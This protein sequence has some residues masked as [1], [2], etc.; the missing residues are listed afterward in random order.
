VFD[1]LLG[2]RLGAAAVEHI[3]AGTT[4]VLLGLRGSAI[5]S[6][7]LD[8]VVATRRTLDPRL[9]DLARVLAR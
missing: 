5:A 8:E 2:T 6:T 3:A 1:R 9:L 4:G 7:P